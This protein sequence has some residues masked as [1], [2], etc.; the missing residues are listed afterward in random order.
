ML[1]VNSSGS[2]GQ[3]GQNTP[4]TTPSLPCS[5]AAGQPGRRQRLDTKSPIPIHTK[6]EENIQ[7]KDKQKKE[8]KKKQERKKGRNR[9]KGNPILSYPIL[10]FHLLPSPTLRNQHT[11]HTKKPSRPLSKEERRGES[12]NGKDI[13]NRHS[14]SGRLWSYRL[15]F[16]GRYTPSIM[17]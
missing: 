6:I 15:G 16:A 8:S 9:R 12:S 2:R 4:P 11:P 3:S 5:R 14:G 10:S 1:L 13:D 17:E 7:N